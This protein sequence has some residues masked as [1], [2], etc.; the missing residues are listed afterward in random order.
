MYCIE[1]LRPAMQNHKDVYKIQSSLRHNLRDAR[2]SDGR[3]DEARQNMSCL[4][5][6]KIGLFEGTRH[7]LV[8]SVQDECRARIASQAALPPLGLLDT[9]FFDAEPC[10]A[11]LLHSAGHHSKRQRL[12]VHQERVHAEPM[13][14]LDGLHREIRGAHPP[15][16]GTRDDSI[17]LDRPLLHS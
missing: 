17:G 4:A 14:E 9:A 12:Q 8:K 6:R 15:A 13:E 16:T 7:F 1:T 11:R 3:L 5:S 10:G 2:S